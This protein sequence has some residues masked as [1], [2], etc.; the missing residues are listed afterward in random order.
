MN[1]PLVEHPANDYLLG[2]SPDGRYILFA[3]DRNGTL[4]AW[5]ISQEGAGRFGDP[6]LVKQDIGQAIPIGFTGDGSY[7]FAIQQRV[8]NV[9]AVDLDPVT[10]KVN[11]PARKIIRQFEGYNEAPAF[12]PDGK[13]IAYISSRSP[14]IKPSGFVRGGNMLCI[15][16]LETGK[17]SE[18]KPSLSRFGYPSWSPD[19]NYIGVLHMALDGPSDLCQ[20]DV[21]T[22]DVTLISKPDE[23]H[24]QFGGHKWSPD[25]KIFYFG[26]REKSTRSFN[27]VARDLESGK[28]KI[29]Y[30]SDDFYIFSISPDGRWFAL[31]CPSN[32]DA[33]IMVV[34][35]DGEQSRILHRFE[36]GIKLGNIPSNAWSADN[37]YIYF[38]M[39]DPSTDPEDAGKDPSSTLNTPIYE[40]CR[41]LV[42]GGSPEKLGL[43]MPSVFLNLSMHPGGQKIAFSSDAQFIS[44]IWVMENFLPEK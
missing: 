11:D 9:Y 15:E 37:K 36:E 4:S 17:V 38:N 42:D 18:I 22:G 32:E 3:S 23:D 40:L 43:K 39:H 1:V 29:I 16:S 27:L 26:L 14:T 6:V 19:G 31:T 7:Y 12:S 5:T 44:E 28:D 30:R 25:G 33:K 2:C 8:K 34:S 20:I 10:G 41:I 13:F 21:Q 24:S 35:T